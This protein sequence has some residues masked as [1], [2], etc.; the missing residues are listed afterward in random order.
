MKDLRP[1]KPIKAEPAVHFC[2]FV[3][4]L[5]DSGNPKRLGSCAEMRREVPYELILCKA[6]Q[7]AEMGIERYVRQIVE[8]GKDGRLMKPRHS[9]HEEKAQSAFS[10]LQTGIKLTENV[11]RRNKRLFIAQKRRERRIVFVNDQHERVEREPGEPNAELVEKRDPGHRVI[12]E[13]DA[14]ESGK[15]ARN[16]RRTE[17]LLIAELRQPGAIQPNDR[18]RPVFPVFRNA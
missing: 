5:I 2:H 9:G 13:A 6:R 1:R 12:R 17:A 14:A 11:P 7:S 4:Q 8:R 10:F 18:I 16:Q 15:K 3:D